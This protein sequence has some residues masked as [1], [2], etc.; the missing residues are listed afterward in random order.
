MAILGIP[1]IELMPAWLIVLL[2]ACIVWA[3][4]WKGIALWKSARNNQKIWFIVFLIVNT[5]GIL[6]IFYILFWAKKKKRK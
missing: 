2:I 1:S 6:E 3:I 4:P 5:L